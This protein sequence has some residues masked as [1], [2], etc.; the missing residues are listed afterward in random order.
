MIISRDDAS[1]YLER[2]HCHYIGNQSQAR[3]RVKIERDTYAQSV[4]EYHS[5]PD[6]V[7]FERSSRAGNPQ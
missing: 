6:Y 5:T 7:R 4:I 2:L 1:W 3:L